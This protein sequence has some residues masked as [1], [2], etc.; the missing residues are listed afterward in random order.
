MDN[1]TPIWQLT[2]GEF[3]ELMKE[4]K[5]DVPE[6]KYDYGISGIARTF[7]CS[8]STAVR[9]KASGK[10]KKAITQTGRKIVIDVDLALSLKNQ[11]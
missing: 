8:T 7:G 1:S 5:P 2:V 10:F 3:L 9:I 6:K 4:K 11:K